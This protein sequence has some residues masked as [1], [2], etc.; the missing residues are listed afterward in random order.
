MPAASL[1]WE[2]ATAAWEVQRR[3]TR[4][5]EAAAALV[6]AATMS[7]SRKKEGKKDRKKK[8]SGPT[9]DFYLFFPSNIF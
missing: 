3:A 2:E 7:F 1:Y 8:P 9:F 6:R 4:R 5:K